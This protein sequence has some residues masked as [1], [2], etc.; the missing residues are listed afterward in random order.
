MRQRQRL[1]YQLT[2]LQVTNAYT[3]QFP[4]VK[5]NSADVGVDG[6]TSRMISMSFVALYDATEATNLKITRPS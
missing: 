6:P 1:K 3:F 2:T 4:K 5:I